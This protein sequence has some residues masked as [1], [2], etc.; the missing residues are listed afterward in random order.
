MSVFLTIRAAGP[1]Q[2]KY[3]VLRTQKSTQHRLT[4]NL[5]WNHPWRLPLA[6]I[7]SLKPGRV[8]VLLF[9]YNQTRRA[10]YR[11]K[12]S[13]SLP[14]LL[15]LPFRAT[16]PLVIHHQYDLGCFWLGLLCVSR[17]H[18]P[19]GPDNKT[20]VSLPITCPDGSVIC[21]CFSEHK[22]H[23]GTSEP[24]TRTCLKPLGH[25][26]QRKTLSKDIVP[27]STARGA[28]FALLAFSPLLS[29]SWDER[30]I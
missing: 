8:S 12:Q 5:L 13:D 4:V 14:Y 10:W 6:A 1:R 19:A 20:Q 2:A 18:P 24:T 9:S 29:V 28:E 22:H 23:P 15:S 27:S 11:S 25:I 16:T 21:G 30:L 7:L 26:Y 3:S 17:H